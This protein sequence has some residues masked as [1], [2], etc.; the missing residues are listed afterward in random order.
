MIE[1]LKSFLYLF[2]LIGKS[3]QLLIFNNYRNISILS[4][5]I[6]LII[7]LISIA[8]SIYS[9]LEYLKYINP[10]ITYSK[11]NDGETNRNIY[12]RDFLLMFQLIDTTSYETLDNSIG[13]YVAEY[14]IVYNNGTNIYTPLDIETCEIGKNMD[15]KYQNFV[16]DKSTYG[17]KIEEFKCISSKF[18]NIS[19]FYDPNVGFSAINLYIIFQNNTNYTPEKIQSLLIAENNIINHFNKTDPINKGYM[20]QLTSAYSSMEYT[21]VNFNFQYLKYESDEGFF[22]QESRILYGMS[23]SDI[24]S[25][26]NKQNNKYLTKNFEEIK[27]SMI[28]TIEFGINKSNFDNYKRSYQKLQSLLAEITSVINLLFEVGRQISNILGG[29]KMSLRIIEYLVNK[30]TLHIK[31]NTNKIMLIKNKRNE[32]SIGKVKSEIFDNSNNLDNTTKSNK[33][34]LSE[35][36]NKISE[37][38]NIDKKNDKNKFLKEINFYHILKSFLCFKDKKSQFINFCYNIITK[39]MSIERILERFYNLEKINYYLSNEEKRKLKHI[40]NKK[41]LEIDKKI[42]EI[43]DEIV[44]EEKSENKNLI[45]NLNFNKEIK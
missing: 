27:N 31:K 17:R 43:N 45:P 34:K 8:F 39:D 22:F 28:G 19:L 24:T 14:I 4:S 13:Y 25:Y 37:N 30:D 23:F 20:F 18:E 9:I 6:S 29:K 35:N 5:L 32:S 12:K 42:D 36:N 40:K 33:I 26:R 44:K 1:S 11:D 10:N 41:F 7:I 2:D 21:K 15:K 38:N 3:P 16:N